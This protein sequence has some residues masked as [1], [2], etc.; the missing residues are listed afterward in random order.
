MPELLFV[1]VLAVTFLFPVLAIALMVR[2]Q[3]LQ[4]RIDD[5]ES[6][7]RQLRGEVREPFASARVERAPAAD[8]RR[9]EPRAQAAQEGSADEPAD[10]HEAEA[11]GEPE[12]E[13]PPLPRKTPSA[14]VEPQEPPPLPAPAPASAPTSPAPHRATTRVHSS[15]V[16]WERWLG[17]RGAAVVGGI[18]LVFAGIFFVQ[19]AIE[20]GWLGPA[21]RDLLALVVGVL[22]IAAHRPLIE[23]GYRSL[24]EAL[25]GAGTVL[26]YGAAWAASRL[27]GLVPEARA[28]ALMAATTGTALLLAVRSNALVLASFALVGGFA[29]PLLLG[30]AGDGPVALFGYVL[31]LDAGLVVASR[32]RR[33][34]WMLPFAV[35]G[36][37][38][39]QTVWVFTGIR[40]VDRFAGALVLGTFAVAF[41][42]LRAITP[43]DDRN[44]SALRAAYTLSLLAPLSLGTLLGLAGRGGTVWADAGLLAVLNAC[45][46]LGARPLRTA[47]V[48]HVTAAVSAFVL[49]LVSTIPRYENGVLFELGPA[50]D[51]FEAGLWIQWATSSV[52][53]AA[54]LLLLVRRG[55]PRATA[56]TFSIVSLLIAP[57]V[58]LALV[59]AT[60]TWR[61]VPPT[62]VHA[63]VVLAAATFTART[64][65]TG[66]FGGLVAGHALAFSAL[67]I[68]DAAPP[69]GEPLMVA[70]AV[71]AVAFALGGASLE[72]A[73]HPAGPAAIAASA[74]VVVAPMLHLAEKA[75][76][77]SALVQCAALLVVGLVGTRLLA[78]SIGWSRAALFTQ[79]GAATIVLITLADAALREPVVGAQSALVA[80]VCLLA[81]AAPL[82]LVSFQRLAREEG[83]V[84]AWA[85][86]LPAAVLPFGPAAMVEARSG[87]EAPWHAVLLTVAAA[88]L[89]AG[90]VLQRRRDAER[91]VAVLLA[92]GAALAGLSVARGVAAEWT[93]V[94]SALAGASFAALCGRAL[95]PGP[96]ALGAAV[97]VAASLALGGATFLRGAFLSEP[98]LVPLQVTVDHALVVAALVAAALGTRRLTPGEPAREAAFRASAVAALVTLFGWVNAVVLNHY[99][100][101]ARIVIARERMQER[102]LT[103]SLAWALFAAALLAAGVARRV[104][105]L[106]WA[107]LI[108]LVATVLKV[109]LYDLGALTGLARV[110][111]FLGLAVCLLGVSLLYARVLGREF[112]RSGGRSDTLPPH[113]DDVP[114][115][116]PDGVAPPRRG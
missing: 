61:V 114:D 75:L 38:A 31:V 52:G 104:T 65:R 36:T 8:E 3:G 54:L 25:G 83:E 30:T 5:L 69:L 95:S 64:R 84:L 15:G 10:E 100:T 103:L 35:L 66:A 88:L 99:A 14:Q 80:G 59:D 21:A 17:V 79:C 6:L 23:R 94:A 115:P 63:L 90:A 45:A 67:L 62:V 106:R 113:D 40:M 37:S 49:G 34:T 53:I 101:G 71:L 92:S 111:S 110:G 82:A 55:A 89:A 78:A 7:V 41:S 70:I 2:T 18:A 46:A 97:A 57:S 4:R 87:V 47:P 60:A 86:I 24:A 29:T 19:V 109:F 81:V 58:G 93:I 68:L 76:E 13:P 98:Q 9:E 73:G 28:L 74:F 11:A 96:A 108:V 91:A 48:A 1:A 77:T 16:D 72:R 51:A 50:R 56:Y 105:G 26:V 33:W 27:H 12:A 102:D 32:V 43:A 107:S 22:G 39:L 85:A 20:R 42:L 44:R 116:R 112:E